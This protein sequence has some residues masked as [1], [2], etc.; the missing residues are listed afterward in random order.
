MILA[1]GAVTFV[2]RCPVCAGVYGCESMQFLYT[3]GTYRYC[4]CG[5]RLI[6]DVEDA[7]LGH[8]YRMT[9]PEHL[10]GS[11]LQRQLEDRL[12]PD[13]VGLADECGC[14]LSCDC[15]IR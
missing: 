8:H 15:S 2:W 6:E 11:R 1:E 13:A 7:S 3:D 4:S 10:R 5:G 12:G 9:I 14:H